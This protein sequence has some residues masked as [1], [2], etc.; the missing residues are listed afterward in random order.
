MKRKAGQSKHRSGE[1]IEE[2]SSSS[3]NAAQSILLRGSHGQDG[4]LH[5]LRRTINGLARIRNPIH[6]RHIPVY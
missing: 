3:Q 2:S 5:P 1:H 4:R 6:R